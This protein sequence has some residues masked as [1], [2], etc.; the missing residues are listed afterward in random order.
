LTQYS[1]SRLSSFENCPRQ[2]AYRY[3]ENIETQREGIEAFV[4]KRV[5]E[6]LERLY[7]HVARHGKPPSLAQVQARF[8]SDWL[9]AWHDQ[10]EIV[11][12]E[13]DIA[14]YQQLGE[15]CLDNYYRRNYP[16]DGEET[17]GI[18]HRVQFNLDP[19]GRYKLRGV[20]D[21][22]V[23]S[24]PG[25]YEIHD[26]KTG[27]YLPPKK[28]IDSDRQLALYQIGLSQSYEDAREF[29]LVWHYLAHNRTLRSSRTAEQLD[30]LR[31]ETIALI[32]RIESTTEYPPRTSALCRWCEFRQICPAQRD[33]DNADG[34]V[35]GDPG[36]LLSPV[37]AAIPRQR[38]LL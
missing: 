35:D 12:K 16:F 19:A 1:H 5:H 21:R 3:V 6:I 23:R 4:G 30:A 33:G 26:Y 13:N 32:D 2:F 37:A 20:I 11:R 24:G 10:V 36:S 27:G 9:A 22:V 15:R 25:R 38:S 14:H 18:E 31:G 7:H 8:R 34:G 17:V 28:R 29:E